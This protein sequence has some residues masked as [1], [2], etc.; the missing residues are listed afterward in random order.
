METTMREWK[1]EICE[2][3][4]CAS[5]Y[6]VDIECEKIRGPW[7]WLSGEANSLRWKPVMIGTGYY[8][9]GF[10][11]INI[12]SSDNE[13]EMIKWLENDIDE[14][15][16]DLP[17]H[18]DSRNRFD[19]M[20]LKGRFINARRP[21]AEENGEWPIIRGSDRWEQFYCSGKLDRQFESYTWK[22]YP[23]MIR[24]G[25]MRITEHCARD[26]IQNLIC[27]SGVGWFKEARQFVEDPTAFLA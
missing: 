27:L 23:K 25:D 19:E 9:D 1:F 11:G 5:L 3:P 10:I 4:K 18:Y 17:I 12:A 16:S 22:Q 14:L 13:A 26:V 24:E 15:D 8:S 7:V 2:A 20:V 6:T 21:L